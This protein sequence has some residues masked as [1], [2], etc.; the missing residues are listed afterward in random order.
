VQKQ[1]QLAAYPDVIP[2][3]EIITQDAKCC[4]RNFLRTHLSEL[5]TKHIWPYTTPVETLG[6]IYNGLDERVGVGYIINEIVKT[7][8]SNEFHILG[9][10]PDITMMVIGG[11]V[12]SLDSIRGKYRSMS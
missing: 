5:N 9:A 12:D 11:C 3:P 8:S 6:R 7:L 10:L 1:S 4:V 2:G